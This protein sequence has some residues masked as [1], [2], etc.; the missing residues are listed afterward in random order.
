MTVVARVQNTNPQWS[1]DRRRLISWGKAPILA[2]GVPVD[3][4][5]KVDGP[6]KVYALDVTGA[7]QNQIAATYKNGTLQFQVSPADGTT[8]FSVEG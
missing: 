5:L 3:V 2:E 1:P 7:R 6:R 8:W 4:T